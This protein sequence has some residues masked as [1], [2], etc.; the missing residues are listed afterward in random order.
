M[1]FVY[2]LSQRKKEKKKEAKQAKGFN[3]LANV[4]YVTGSILSR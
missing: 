2:S 3:G 1:A 4:N